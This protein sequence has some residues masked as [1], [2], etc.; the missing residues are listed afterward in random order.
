MPRTGM[1][2]SSS[3]TRKSS[4]SRSSTSARM[5]KVYAETSHEAKN[6]GSKGAKRPSPFLCHG[7]VVGGGPHQ[8]ARKR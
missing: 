8:G 6:K 1:K 5:T 4:P 7:L 2:T 3:Q